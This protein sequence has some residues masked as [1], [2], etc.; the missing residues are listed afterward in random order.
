MQ[1]LFFDS[2]AL[3]EIYKGNKNYKKYKE[4]KVI[5][6]YLH[7]YEL[8]YSLR[9]NYSEE[10]IRDFFQFL[11]S[12]CVNLKFEWIQK[13]VEFRLFY[14]KRDLS[15]ADCLGYIIAKDLG[16]RF[17]TGDNQFKDLSNVEFVK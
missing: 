1:S 8:Y 9:K 7:L 11:Q 5:T 17:L 13:A 6:S 16:I 3:L 14:K 15:Y 12:F 4:I 2:Y 10:E